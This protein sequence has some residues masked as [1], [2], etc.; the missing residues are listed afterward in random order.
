M[1][2]TR[3]QLWRRRVNE[4]TLDQKYERNVVLGSDH[5]NRRQSQSKSQFDED[6]MASLEQDCLLSRKGREARSKLFQDIA[7]ND[8]SSQLFRQLQQEL[9]ENCHARSHYASSSRRARTGAYGSTTNTGSTVTPST[10]AAVQAVL[11]QPE[12]LK[13][14]GNCVLAQH[15]AERKQQAEQ[16]NS[17]HDT[18]NNKLGAISTSATLIMP[19]RAVPLEREQPHEQSFQVVPPRNWIQKIA[20][21]RRPQR[22]ASERALTLTASASCTRTWWS[23]KEDEED[24]DEESEANEESQD[25]IQEKE[26]I[27][28]NSREIEDIILPTTTII[29]GGAQTTKAQDEHQEAAKAAQAG[30]TI[31]S[32]SRHNNQDSVSIESCSLLTMQQPPSNKGTM[33]TMTAIPG[34]ITGKT[35]RRLFAGAA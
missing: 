29:E 10:T 4:C 9:R 15:T 24:K 2:R 34:E 7:I 16:D 27:S 31:I 5:T 32:M 8:S 25:E 18:N 23:A 26:E 13:H 19:R 30:T 14:M 12:V 17:A 28:E 22:S 3:L 35:S 21:R 6:C 33:S 20:L 11:H 1:R